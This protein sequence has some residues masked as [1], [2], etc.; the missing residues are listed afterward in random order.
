[1]MIFSFLFSGCPPNSLL[2]AHWVTNIQTIWIDYHHPSIN[3]TP[4]HSS[5]QAFLFCSS[6]SSMPAVFQNFLVPQVRLPAAGG[7]DG[8]AEALMGKVEPGGNSYV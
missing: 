5:A 1:M 4:N 2:D 6:P 7:E 8:L 3:F